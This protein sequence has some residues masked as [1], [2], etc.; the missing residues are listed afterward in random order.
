MSAPIF[1]YH[2]WKVI[3]SMP[4]LCFISCNFVQVS[5]NEYG[6]VSELDKMFL[7]LLYLICFQ[8]YIDISYNVIYY[9]LTSMGYSYIALSHKTRSLFG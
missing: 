2:T 1:P 5:F 8:S 4:F 7:Y 3:N 9:L 6:I